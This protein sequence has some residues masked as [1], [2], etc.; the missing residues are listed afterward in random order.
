VLIP[1]NVS[2]T[3]NFVIKCC[4]NERFVEKIEGG[5][6]FTRHLKSLGNTTS[7]IRIIT[8]VSIRREVISVTDPQAQKVAVAFFVTTSTSS[9][10]HR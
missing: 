1:L 10:H 6:L 3:Y 7:E 9:D 8:R 5:Q 4:S 2:E